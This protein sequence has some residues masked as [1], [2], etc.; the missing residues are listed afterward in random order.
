MT[1]SSDSSVLSALSSTSFVKGNQAEDVA[2]DTAAQVFVL[3]MQE[4]LP[5]VQRLRD[6]A[7]GVLA[8]Q[9]GE[10]AIDVGCG[11]GTEVRRMAELV[12][13]SGRAIGVEPHHGLHAE[14]VRRSAGTT[15]TFL[16]GAAADLP[17]EDGSVDV[18]RCER[19]FQHL[20]DPDAA[21]VEFARVL[22]PGGRVVIIDSDWDTSV[23]TPG[24][25]DVLARLTAFRRGE[26]PNPNSGRLLRGQLVRAGLTVD[27]DIAATAVIP[28]PSALTMLMKN[29]CENAATAGAITQAEGEE[30]L[31]VTAAAQQSGEGFMAV[32]MFGVL[33]RK[34]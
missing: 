21:A 7:L 24:D 12:G 31:A 27:P 19:V 26:V 5:G 17:F 2:A 11:A 22:A 30:L 6:W 18:I 4:S 28:P 25:A 16:D 8:P 10:V 33:G 32:T 3:D 1:E 23:Q 34:P 14:A 29:M 20:H 13:A 9:R 15:A